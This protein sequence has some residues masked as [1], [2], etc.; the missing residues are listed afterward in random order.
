[1]HTQKLES[2]LRSL[3]G[4]E[5]IYF[6]IRPCGRLE[7][8]GEAF[9]ARLLDVD[10]KKHT[11]KIEYKTQWGETRIEWVDI[12]WITSI[13]QFREDMKLLKKKLRMERNRRKREQKSELHKSK[14]QGSPLHKIIRAK[15][16]RLRVW[17]RQRIQAH[18][19]TE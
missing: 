18:D 3:K 12:E 7:F 4:R 17:N 1:M 6:D 2:T 13:R 8:T 9:I 19:R 10:L 5:V 11:A 16:G 15:T 14:K